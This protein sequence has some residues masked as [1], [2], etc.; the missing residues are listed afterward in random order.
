MEVSWVFRILQIL[1]II[2]IQSK[3]VDWRAEWRLKK[4][5]LI[6]FVGKNLIVY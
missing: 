6:V 1:A 2:M 4:L 5:G 3:L